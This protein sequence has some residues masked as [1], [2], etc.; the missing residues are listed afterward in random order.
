[1]RRC[2]YVKAFAL[3]VTMAFVITGCSGSKPAGQGTADKQQESGKP[4]VLRVGHV[5]SEEHPYHLGLLKFKELVEQKTNGKVEVQVFPSSQLGNER[6]MLEG[7]KLGTLEMALTGTG[8]TQ[9]YQKKLSLFSLPY[10]FRDSEHAY[11]VADGPIGQELYGL[12]EQN[13]IKVLAAYENGF[14]Q[15]SN[16]K[17]PINSPADLKGLKIRTPEAEIYLDTLKAMGAN[18]FPMASGEV[19]TALQQGTMDGQENALIH[20]WYSKVWE[21]QKYIAIT[22]HIYDPAPLSI[23]LK[24]WNSLPKDIQE[25][26]AAAAT[27][28]RDYQRQVYQEQS[29]DAENKLREKG[30]EITKPD[31]APFREAVQQVWQKYEP[32]IGKDLIDKAVNTK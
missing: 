12:L 17:R 11:K 8:V 7:L 25:A 4:I 23:S 15:V 3:L 27:E 1:M 10:I 2:F 19:Y 22:N 5:L 24:T 30:I 32:V 6:D 26:V 21:V 13:G 18:S 16:N 20:I 31:L 29:K 9:N 14:R 28:S